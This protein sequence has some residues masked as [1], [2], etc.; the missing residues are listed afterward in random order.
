MPA[1]PSLVL[2]ESYV[3]S[4]EQSIASVRSQY[5]NLPPGS[6][7]DTHYNLAQEH[8]QYYDN[9][10]DARRQLNEYYSR[11]P[12]SQSQT[13]GMD[14]SDQTP[15]PAPQVPD[16]LCARFVTQE[17]KVTASLKTRQTGTHKQSTFKSFFQS[18]TSTG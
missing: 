18:V 14:M 2:L 9:L 6:S 12:A 3:R 5:F 17:V 4:L 7:W 1:E 8:R 10:Y 11:H 13:P 16:S 15:A